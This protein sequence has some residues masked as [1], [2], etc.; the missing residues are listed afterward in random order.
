MFRTTSRRILTIGK[1]GFGISNTDS[2]NYI[3]RDEFLTNASITNGQTLNCEPI[4][5]LT[6]SE[7][8]GTIA[9][10]NGRLTF[11]VQTT[12]TYGDLGW[13]NVG[14]FSRIAGRV[15]GFKFSIDAVTGS[16]NMIFGAWGFNRH[17]IN[18]S[19]VRY[20]LNCFNASLVLAS[21]ISGFVTLETS[22][23]AVST[24]YTVALILN[25]TGC[26]YWIKGGNFSDWTRVHYDYENS[27]LT[28]WPCGAA[29]N[30]AGYW[31][32]ISVF[33][34]SPPN[35]YVDTTSVS[36]GT[37]ISALLT[38]FFDLFISTLPSPTVGA[39]IEWRFRIQDANNYFFMHLLRNAGDTNWDVHLKKVTAG[40]TST[41]VS[42]VN[43][44]NIDVMRIRIRSGNRIQMFTRNLSN[45]AWTN[46]GTEQT[47]S[48]FSSAIT[49]SPVYTLG[50][51]SRIVILNRNDTV[52]SNRLNYFLA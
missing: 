43:V 8:D 14:G 37:Q 39:S 2:P 18:S 31:K 30:I 36:S 17:P 47:D 34:T 50:T 49:V 5:N 11:T 13:R 6:Y 29:N 27:D 38:G 9:K 51:I 19:D 23:L 24:E 4:G 40:V 52:V 44:N 22:A 12:P 10:N 41:L 46:R 21:G 15:L 45:G 7:V 1:S 20:G 42:V 48:A 16:T 28:V 3:L 25:T 26:D 33:N 32:D 35:F